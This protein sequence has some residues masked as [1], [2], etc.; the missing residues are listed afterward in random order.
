MDSRTKIAILL[1][2]VI[3]AANLAITARFQKSRV[4]E[5]RPR[6]QPTPEVV[7][8]ETAAPPVIHSVPETPAPAVDVA[9]PFAPAVPGEGDLVVETPLQRLRIARAGGV[10]RQI[11]LSRYEITS[12]KTP[13][14][15]TRS[16][17]PGGHAL[18]IVLR[19]GGTSWDLSSAR[20]EPQ[21]GAFGTDG[22]LSLAAGSG[23][24]SFELRCAATGGG[25]LVER[26]TIDPDRY[27][28]GVE[29]HLEPGPGLPNVEAYTLEWTTGMPVTESN[30]KEDEM[31]FRAVAALDGQV[32]RRRPGDFKRDSSQS[33][34]GTLR[35][36]C[37]QSKYFMVGLIP[38]SPQPGT[39]EIIGE[40]KSHWIGMR[41][42]QPAAWRTGPEAYRIYAGPIAFD[43]VRSLGVG[44]E[45][46]VELGWR[47]IRPISGLLLHFMT[48]L[49]KFI[50][51][52]GVII[53]IVS[54]LAK[55]VFWP[56]TD[57]SMKSMRRMQDLQPRMEEIRRRYA[58]NA[59]E[60]NAQMM[61]LY[62][63][64]RVNPV[65]GCMPILI[66]TPMFFAL[67]SVLQSNIELRNAPFVGWIDNLAAPD[68]LAKL[69]FALPVIGDHFSLL[70]LL[71]GGTMIWQSVL[72]AA[73]SPPAAS[74]PMAQ[75]QFLMKWIMPIMMTFIF[76]RMPSGLVIYWIVNTLMSIA[77]QIQINRKLGP[78][79]AL[80]VARAAPAPAAAAERGAQHG[81]ADRVER[82]E[83]GRGAA[84]RPN[85]AGRPAR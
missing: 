6:S 25:A 31:R 23:A 8:P 37:I 53:L 19:G 41:F 59:Q 30:S 40:P 70:P 13:V 16:A 14:D 46:T 55:L 28:F 83:R 3:L 38:D 82:P 68:V 78:A 56:L 1:V 27:D 64:Q 57:R 22:V 54:V 69:P 5:S 7:R 35:W 65:G 9:G 15:L 17:V 73:M 4:Q 18:G 80:A 12:S 66:Q 67:F 74:G 11:V 47:W 51:N 34:P 84:E 76:Y 20:F 24:R 72:G 42:T 71:M 58:G 32:L 43:N 10:L 33:F 45:S 52:Y 85:R 21:P 77:Q 60:M 44:L 39:L 36:S 61:N 26:F 29:L 75:Q 79:R 63:E 49:N 62:R 81:G 48:F 50:P 2:A